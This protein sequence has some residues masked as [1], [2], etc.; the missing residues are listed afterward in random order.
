MYRSILLVLTVLTLYLPGAAVADA[1]SERIAALTRQV[2][3]LNKKVAKLEKT[4]ELLNAIRPTVTT[5]M[6]DVAERFHVMHYAGDAEDW[7]LA[8]HEMHGI[9]HLLGV[10][11]DVDPEKGAMARGFLAADLEHVDA[12]IDSGNRDAF[13]KAI[14]H[15]VG[16]CNACH[17]AV[18]SPFMQVTLNPPDTLSL[19]HSHKLMHSKLS[20]EHEHEHEHE[21]EHMEPASGG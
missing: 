7:A 20:A 11:K 19:R 12:A 5:L 21:E 13:D 14:T 16:D 17:T 4:V 10:I 1:Q 8:S 15:M 3:S 18:G 6:P 9:E 2:D